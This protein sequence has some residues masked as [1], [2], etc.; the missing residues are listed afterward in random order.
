VSMYETLHR[1]E[2]DFSGR[3]PAFTRIPTCQSQIEGI[4]ASRSALPRVLNGDCSIP[5][6]YA[7]PEF[8]RASESDP[9]VEVVP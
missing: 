7:R 8:N 4:V 3:A 2:Q 1:R 5:T 6:A 9:G